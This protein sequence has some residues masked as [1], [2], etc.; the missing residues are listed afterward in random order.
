MKLTLF[1]RK[2]GNTVNIKSLDN[3]L[4]ELTKIYVAL[5]DMYDEAFIEEIHGSEVKIIT[6]K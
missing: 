4:C 1:L 3:S 6:L 2:N 5:K